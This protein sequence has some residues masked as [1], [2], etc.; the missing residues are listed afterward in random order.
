MLVL[1]PHLGG[2]DD[3]VGS[4]GV[5]SLSLVDPVESGDVAPLV[6]HEREVD[7]EDAAIAGVQAGKTLMHHH[8]A[9]WSRCQL[10]CSCSQNFPCIL[11]SC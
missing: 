5:A 7:V 10:G 3:E 8:T 11:G 9:Q 2:V 1:A 6:L 4:V